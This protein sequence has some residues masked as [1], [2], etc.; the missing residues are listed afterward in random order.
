MWR[1]E[2]STIAARL[3]DSDR[4]SNAGFEASTSTMG[5]GR[6]KERQTT[7][8]KSQDTTLLD[9][10]GKR[11]RDQSWTGQQILS[12]TRK[13]PLLREQYTCVKAQRWHHLLFL[14]PTF[15]DTSKLL[16]VPPSKLL[17]IR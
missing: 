4:L 8:I 11:L 9:W 15:V 2:L 7:A 1:Q 12:P 6:A 3:F 13:T 5:E 14:L 10:G 17:F 16:A